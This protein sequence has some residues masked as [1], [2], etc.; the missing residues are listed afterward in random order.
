MEDNSLGPCEV[1]KCDMKLF[2]A[3]IAERWPVKWPVHM[4]GLVLSPTPNRHRL[5]SLFTVEWSL[6]SSS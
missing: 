6:V 1:A 2:N 3:T 4:P 5:Q